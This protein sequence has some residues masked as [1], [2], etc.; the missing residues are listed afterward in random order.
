VGGVDEC[1]RV[2]LGWVFAEEG[3]EEVAHFCLKYNNELSIA[4]MPC[5]QSK[6][7]FIPLR[8]IW[9]DVPRRSKLE[10]SCSSRL[11]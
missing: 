6:Y 11:N 4:A 8:L 7:A 3:V 1:S 9:W 5:R 10:A 2:G